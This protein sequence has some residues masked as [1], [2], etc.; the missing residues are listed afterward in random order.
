MTEDEQ[1]IRD[2]VRRWME[3]SKVG[4]VDTVLGL[5]TDDVV[6][7][8]PGRPPMIGKAAYAEAA[9]PQQGPPGE[10][11]AIDGRSEIQEVQVAG[12]WGFLWS[13]LSVTVTPP[14]GA[15]PVK[16]AGHT[17]TVFR[18]ENGKWLLAR[19]ANL[20]VKVE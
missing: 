14:G 11:L 8:Q 16:R 2:V 5:M 9:K 19:D 13:K 10:R 3:A 6:F 12:E 1:A 18:K 4:D 20:L 17:L 7:L 15:P